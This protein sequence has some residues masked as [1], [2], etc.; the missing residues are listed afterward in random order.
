LN[1]DSPFAFDGNC[2]SD[3]SPPPPPGHL[4]LQALQVTDYVLGVDYLGI[5]QVRSTRRARGW[6]VVDHLVGL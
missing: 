2:F 6:R 4:G 5:V 1:L 3:L